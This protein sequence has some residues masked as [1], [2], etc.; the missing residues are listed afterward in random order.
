MAF[1]FT[2]ICV[3]DEITALKIE[4]FDIEVAFKVHDSFNVS[5]IMNQEA[6]TSLKQIKLG[7]KVLVATARSRLM[8]VR[9]I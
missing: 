5:L 3:K 2:C 9:T 1:K 8:W 6:C 4:N 7:Q